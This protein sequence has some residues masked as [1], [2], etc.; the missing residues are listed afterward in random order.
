M[1]VL[2][3]RHKTEYSYAH[4]VSFGEHRVMLRPRDSHDLRVIEK[5]LEISPQPKALRWI[6]DV[7]GNS[8]GI[9]KFE[10]RSDRLT[11][12]SVVTIEHMPTDG[13]QLSP[14][15]EAYLYPFSYDEDELPDLQRAMHRLFPDRKGELEGW[16][17]QFTD[18]VTRI[19]TVVDT[20]AFA[21][22]ERASR[23]VPVVG[24]IGT[25]SA[26]GPLL[27]LLPLLE[28]LASRRPLSRRNM[29]R[30]TAPGRLYCWFVMRALT[31]P[32]RGSDSSATHRR[33]THS[34]SNRMSS[35]K[36][37][38]TLCLASSIAWLR[39]GAEPSRRAR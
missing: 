27:D 36:K 19:P 1:P 31:P 4:P 22:R 29:E 14:D 17:R 5:R 23:D 28:E 10:T 37:K 38:M 13:A 39:C 7:F 12:N 32:S 3:I 26:L 35:S 25:P 8:V 24:W 6:H 16:A 21:P 9:A 33:A 18:R 11:F 20:V 34:G 30:L 15:D 2:T